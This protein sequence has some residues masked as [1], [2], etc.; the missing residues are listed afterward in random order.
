MSKNN[1][2]GVEIE[3]KYIIKMP[4][5]STISA[6]DCYTR[7]EI[8]QIYLPSAGSETHR[9]RRRIFDDKTVYTETRKIRLDKMSATE[10]EGEIGEE[11]FDFFAKNPLTG[12]TP[13]EKTRHTF[14]YRGQ[15][16][17]IDVYPQWINTAIME[18]ELPD[19]EKLVDFPEFIEIICEVT[20]D[21]SYSNAGMSRKF[22]SEL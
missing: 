2:I 19:R 6:Q 18:T 16:F 12:Y 15:L 1:K 14:I 17:E 10:I 13:I 8:L 22:P 20:G 5:F 4:D 11:E 21:K 7:S 9:I 3:R